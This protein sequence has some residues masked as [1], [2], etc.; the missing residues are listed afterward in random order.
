MRQGMIRT[1]VHL[2][3]WC[4]CLILTQAASAQDAETYN[5]RPH[6]T[7]GQTA[8]YEI[9][10]S[11]TQDVSMTFAGQ[12]R[13]AQ[14]VMS[15]EG[16]VL[17]TVDQVKADGSS[18]C[19]M[20]I[21]WLAVEMAADGGKPLKNDSRKG[22]GDIEPFQKL[23]KAMTGVPLKVSVAADGTVT[24][25]TGMKAISSRMET[26]FKELVPEELDFIES[27]T[28]LATLVAVPES[29]TVGKKWDADLKWTWS[30]TP[31]EGHLK[32]DMKYTL[33]GVEEMAG[34]Q[35]AVVE[36]KSKLKL[37]VDRSNLPEGMP[38][39]DVKLVKGESQTQIMYDMSRH[40][41]VGRHTSQST[42]IDFTVRLPNN[43]TLNR[44]LVETLQGQS[45]RIAEE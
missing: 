36:G 28:D 31:F 2:I 39:T 20:T 21:D 34:L 10:S 37:D 43:N 15:S 44:R 5:L 11:R 30:D 16:E 33:A 45:L 13:D 9:W 42:T 35:I 29:V 1:G 41:A 17:W 18:V 27:A 7:Q 38:P 26:D 3:A 14:I 32:H 8:R 22:S 19:T 12:K 23:L 25:V 40:E 6:W 24:K 4:M